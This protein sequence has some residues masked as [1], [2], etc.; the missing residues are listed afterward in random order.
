M[1]SVFVGFIKHAC[2]SHFNCLF[3]F[4][5]FISAKNILALILQVIWEFNVVACI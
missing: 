2:K 5:F 3:T 4:F 1:S